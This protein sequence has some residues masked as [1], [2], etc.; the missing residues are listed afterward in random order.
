[1]ENQQVLKA[2]QGLH[3]FQGLHSGE[4]EIVFYAETNS[5]WLHFEP[6]IRELISDSGGKICYITSDINDPILEKTIP[7]IKSFFIG[8]G[9]SRTEFFKFL[10]V[11]VLAMSMPDLEQFY[12]K[13]SQ[14]QTH[15]V[16]IFQSLIST[17]M[18][19][20]KGAF[21]NYDSI[22]CAGPYHVSEIREAEKLYGL[23]PK[24]LV[25]CGYGHLDNI[26]Q[27]YS[28]ETNKEHNEKESLRVVIAPTYGPQSLSEIFNSELCVELIEILLDAG[29]HVTMR[30]HWMTSH[31]NP[32]A[33]SVLKSRFSEN[34][35]F[36]MEHDIL[37]ISS[38]KNSDVLISD[39]SGI[40]LEYAFG[41]LKPVIYIDLP[42]RVRNVDFDSISMP[43]IELELREE[44]GVILS[45]DKIKEAPRVIKEILKEDSGFKERCKSNRNQWIFN[46]GRSGKIAADHIEALVAE[47]DPVSNEIAIKALHGLHKFRKLP[48][49]KRKIVFYAAAASDWLFFEA[50]IRELIF[51]KKQKICYVTSDPKDPVLERKNP[52]I[53]KIF[54]GCGNSQTDFFDSL[55]AD[56]L[57]MTKPNLNHFFIKCSRFPVHYV[58]VFQTLISTHM[59]QIKGAFDHYDSILCAGP[60]HVDEIRASEKIY[61]LPPKQLIE[62]GYGHLDNILENWVKSKQADQ[63]DIGPVK[64]VIAPTYGPQSLI[65]IKNGMLC[66]DLIDT[67]IKADFH[68][69]LR[70]HWM[71]LHSPA[72]AEI[73]KRFT[74]NRTFTL[75]ESILSS[76]SLVESDIMVSDFSGAALEYAF[77]F[78][79]PVV[80]VDIPPRTRNSE[81][82][83]F[84]L[85]VI[86]LELRQETG[87]ILSPE[88]LEEA[89]GIINE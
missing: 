85:P 35:K 61:G 31:T 65:E 14:T 37:S 46:I 81:Y 9:D 27:N 71:T 11:R 88:H 80:Y 62:C 44:T 82:T 38:L 53:E 1:M 87:F 23:S 16:Y 10:D 47:E 30:P 72:L 2:E 25:E 60:H 28:G 26:I 84:S 8:Y 77:G 34:M 5:D 32:E 89:P 3:Q 19:F 68:V 43:A 40:T 4:R 18:G 29:L 56:V 57:V 22:L 86:E 6:I 83:K 78:L 20:I 15:Y 21:E 41:F 66:A 58:Y 33:I 12:I 39:V 7:G 54:V 73:K 50:I 49:E 13:R 24:K 51:H 36:V 52:A 67:L 76:T 79:K 64:V 69:T 70:P 63:T 55:E 17:H 59:G 42:P 48:V 74:Q 45:P 75:E